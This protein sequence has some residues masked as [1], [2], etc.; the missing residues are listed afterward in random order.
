MACLRTGSFASRSLLQEG[1]SEACLNAGLAMQSACSQEIE[2]GSN[3]FGVSQD[4]Q[5]ALTNLAS[6]GERIQ[7]CGKAETEG[8]L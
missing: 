1:I 8:S 5:E 4:D 6:E 2:Q 3:Y 7:V